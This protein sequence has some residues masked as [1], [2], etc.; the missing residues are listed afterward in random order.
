[1]LPPSNLICSV[2]IASPSQTMVNT[3]EKTNDD[4]SSLARIDRNM[5]RSKQKI[6]GPLEASQ[7][8]STNLQHPRGR[9][10]KS[11]TRVKVKGE[12]NIPKI[13]IPQSLTHS[14]L[15]NNISIGPPP[16]K[17]PQSASESSST[18][19]SSGALTTLRS[20]NTSTPAL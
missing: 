13:P 3:P 16:D 19:A 7:C 17:I 18:T 15:Q 5:L 4:C 11:S 2:T 10:G 14:P 9:E 12:H 20:R 1:M 6:N 8:Q